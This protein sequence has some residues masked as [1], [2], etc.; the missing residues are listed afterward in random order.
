LINKTYTPE[1]R[2][3]RLANYFY[4]LSSNLNKALKEENI[5]RD[6]MGDTRRV[7]FY[8]ARH[9]F[10][11]LIDGLDVPRYLIQHMIGHRT[12][13]LETNYLRRITP[14]EQAQLSNA[15]LSPLLEK[16]VEYAFSFIRQ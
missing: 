7:T 6:E 10:C 5:D 15:I 16:D 2:Q 3:D 11:N 12:T 9:A 4:K 14:W 8:Y 1:Q 13:V